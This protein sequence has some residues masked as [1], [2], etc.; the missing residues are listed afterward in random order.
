MKLRFLGSGTIHPNPHRL[1][2]ATLLENVNGEMILVDCGPGTFLRFAQF[3]LDLLQVRH[4]FI[5]HF[6]P[7][8]IS[9]LIPILFAIRNLP[10]T[11]DSAPINIWGPPGIRRFVDLMV[12]AYGD[13]LSAEKSGYRVFDLKESEALIDSFKVSVRKVP[14]NDESVGYRFEIENFVVGFSGD[15]EY[16]EAIVELISGADLAVVEC[17][18]PDS[19][20]RRGH[21]TPSEVASLAR[22]GKPQRLLINHCYPAVLAE[23][24]VKLIQKNFDGLVVIAH[25]G[26][27]V[28]LRLPVEKS[29]LST[30]GKV[31]P[32]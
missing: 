25:D 20:P 8:H 18:Y 28:D 14:H 4:I 29:V 15:S 9:D 5:T 6:H 16:D 27:I 24:P 12:E 22:L 26:M 19:D 31:D 10:A 13:W 17:A 30:V 2:S 7:D 21:L 1:C 11:G 32:H 3:D 23:D